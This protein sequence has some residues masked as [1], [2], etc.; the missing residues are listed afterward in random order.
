MAPT[1]LGRLE[2]MALGFGLG[3]LLV[4]VAITG[5]QAVI[6]ETAPTRA[7]L[8]AVVAASPAAGIEACPDGWAAR[9][10]AL[11]G[12]TEA[13]VT[14]WYLAESLSAPDARVLRAAM[15]FYA[16]PADH[17]LDGGHPATDARVALCV[18]ESRR[19]L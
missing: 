15:A 11:E 1:R 17:S 2:S 3:A 18:A 13:E 8:E 5:A 4:T 12:L 16:A 19:L 14:A 7:E 9:H 10:A 6:A